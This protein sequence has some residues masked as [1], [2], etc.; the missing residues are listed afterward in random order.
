MPHTDEPSPSNP[1]PDT[2]K[3]SI[4]TEISNDEYH[5][6]ADRYLESVHERAEQLAENRE[7]VDV[8]YSVSPSLRPPPVNSS[9]PNNR[10]STQPS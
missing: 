6:H 7:D 3:I 5:E 8:E 4:P 10:P 2:H 9:K 1:E